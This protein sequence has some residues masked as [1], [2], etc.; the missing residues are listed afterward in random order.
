LSAFLNTDV[1]YR[2]YLGLTQPAIDP[3]TDTE[4]VS[5]TNPDSSYNI[6]TVPLITAAQTLTASFADV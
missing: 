3:S 2:V 1:V 4:K 5:V 6:D